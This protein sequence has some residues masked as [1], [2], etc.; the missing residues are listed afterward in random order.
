MGIVV[1]ND[2]N[3]IGVHTY[4]LNKANP[5]KDGATG[6]FTTGGG[7]GGAGGGGGSSDSAVS[8]NQKKMES[9]L[10]QAK[11]AGMSDSIISSIKDSHAER[12]KG[13]LEELEAGTFEGAAGRHGVSVN[14][15]GYTALHTATVY[16]LRDLTGTGKAEWPKISEMK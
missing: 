2:S 15:K 7:G 13:A 4:T 16:A 9:A 11:T 1:N 8:P 5:Y 3:P 12:D 6:R 14:E 10:E